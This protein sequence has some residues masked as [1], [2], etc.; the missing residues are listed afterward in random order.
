MAMFVAH[1]NWY[2]STASLWVQIQTFIKDHKIGDIN[3]MATTIHR[4]QEKI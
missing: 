2:G 3:G 1:P 4:K